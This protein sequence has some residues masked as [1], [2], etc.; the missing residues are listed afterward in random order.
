MKEGILELNYLNRL[1][2]GEMEEKQGNNKNKTFCDLN[3]KEE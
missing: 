1:L 3:E 2:R